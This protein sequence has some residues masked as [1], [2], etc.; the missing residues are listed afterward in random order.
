MKT[1]I[2]TQRT[3]LVTHEGGRAMLETPLKELRRTLST[4]MLFE[5]TYYEKGTAIADRLAELAGKVTKEQLIQETLHAKNDLKLRHSPLWMARHLARLHTGKLVGNCITDVIQR[6]DELAEFLALYWK[7]GRTPISKQVKRGLANAFMK[8]DEYQFAKYDRDE[9]IKLRDVMFLVHPHPTNN[10]LYKRIA[11]RTLTTPDTWEVK[12][13]LAHTNEEKKQVWETLLSEKKLGA[14]ALF[15]NLRNMEKVGVDRGLVVSALEKARVDKMLPFQFVSAWRYAPAFA[16]SIE[17]AMLRAIS[18]VDKLHGSTCLVLDVSGSMDA[19]L[20]GKSDMTRIDAMSAL[21]LAFNELSDD[22]R[23]WTFSNQVKEIPATRGFALIESIANSQPHGGTYL[24][25]A[26]EAIQSKLN[27]ADRVIVVTDEQAH[28]GI[29]YN[30]NAKRLYLVNVAP[31]QY[32]VDIQNK[33]T[34]INGFST[35]I[36]DWIRQEENEPLFKG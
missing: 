7:S 35:A 18:T 27:G 21:A 16:R 33:W 17:S 34:R 28:D 9:A 11:E 24:A 19:E 36:V 15:R 8:F 13:S 14:F 32:G 2:H 29:Y 31:Y 25:T 6:A 4:C 3:P 22:C 26:L 30:I 10:E 12:L 1:N 23:I 20:S 5:D